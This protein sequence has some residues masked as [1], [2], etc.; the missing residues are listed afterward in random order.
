MSVLSIIHNLTQQNSQFI[1]ATH[2]PIIMA[3]PDSLIYH[4][5]EDGIT[6]VEYTE[7]EHFKVTRDFLNNPDRML[8]VLLSNDGA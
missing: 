3:H 1:I 5:S 4:F 7:I 6:Q 8:R 2:S